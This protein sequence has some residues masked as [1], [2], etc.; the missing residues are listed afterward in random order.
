MRDAQGAPT[1]CRLLTIPAA[2]PPYHFQLD[3]KEGATWSS[4][5]EDKM[6]CMKYLTFFYPTFHT[7]LPSIMS[8]FF[9]LSGAKFFSSFDTLFLG[10]V[11][12]IPLSLLM[13]S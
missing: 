11:L 9:D 7:L 2:L 12:S 1:R 13:A 3:K 8:M 6:K 10:K 4:A 5:A